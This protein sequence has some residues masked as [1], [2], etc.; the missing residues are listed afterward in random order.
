VSAAL[1]LHRLRQ[2]KRSPEWTTALGEAAVHA[3][4]QIGRLAAGALHL[5][6]LLERWLLAPDTA[7]RAGQ[8]LRLAGLSLGG[9]S[10]PETTGIP[11]SDGRY[12]GLL[13]P[14]Q[15]EQ[16]RLFTQGII[17]RAHLVADDDLVIVALALEAAL[18]FTERTADLVSATAA[19]VTG[20]LA[21]LARGLAPPRGA[22]VAQPTLV[23]CQV[24]LLGQALDHLLRHGLPI[25]VLAHN[26]PPRGPDERD[27]ATTLLRDT[28]DLLSNRR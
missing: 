24:N 23:A 14:R 21:A 25:T 18:G 17:R 3:T 13:T 5:E 19:G 11:V 15:V 28:I 27:Q 8:W 10:L 16:M 1:L 6:A 7:A 20:R 26:A 4:R 22:L 2:E 9:E 12:D